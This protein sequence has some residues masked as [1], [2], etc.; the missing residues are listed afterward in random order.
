MTSDAFAAVRKIVEGGQGRRSG[1]RRT[2]NSLHGTA[3]P[4]GRWS[5]FPGHVDAPARETYLN[6][7]CRQLLT[8]YGVVF[9]ELLTRETAAPAWSELVPALRK[10]EL[11]GEVRGGRFVADVAGEQYALPPAVESVR[12]MRDEQPEAEWRVISAADPLN[13]LGILT[14][15]A[16]IPATH[17]NAL[18]LQNGRVVATLVG[19][20]VEYQAPF[21]AAAQW[22]MRGA[23]LRGRKARAEHAGQEGRRP[24]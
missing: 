10:L 15:G 18:V 11:R 12:Q 14:T 22:E 7:W 2:R 1:R 9:R 13:L 24:A 3:A 21:D 17:K 5:L 4:V 20:A 6:H 19:G 8:R 23:L 16:R